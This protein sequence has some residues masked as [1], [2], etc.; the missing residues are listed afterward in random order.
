M[1]VSVN[2]NSLIILC[3]FF[4]IKKAWFL[5]QSDVW[6]LCAEYLVHS[7]PELLSL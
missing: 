3:I 6:L 5:L 7:G 1:A 4:S 2:E